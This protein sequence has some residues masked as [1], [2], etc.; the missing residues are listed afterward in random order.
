MIFLA[1]PSPYEHPGSMKARSD[2]QDTLDFKQALQNFP[3]Q[4]RF[5]R[6]MLR[7]L[8]DNP[9]DFIGAFR[10][11]PPKLQM[12]FVQAWQSFLFNRF[13]SSRIKNDFGLSKAEIGDYVV[14]VERSGLP[15]IHS[16]KITESRN[17]D[18]FKKKTAR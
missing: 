11:L 13:L 17:V 1:K 10:R 7:H 5:E 16:Y 18:A 8:V 3:I 14:N 9:G 4:L 2:L 15:L 6:M 12:M